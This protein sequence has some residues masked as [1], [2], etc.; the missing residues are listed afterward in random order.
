MKLLVNVQGLLTTVL[1]KEES[2]GTSERSSTLRVRTLGLVIF[3]S[4]ALICLSI[5][6]ALTEDH[7]TT[8]Q[9]NSRSLQYHGTVNV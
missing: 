7:M 6:A 5:V 3:V 1:H 4:F 8:G 9:T 2:D